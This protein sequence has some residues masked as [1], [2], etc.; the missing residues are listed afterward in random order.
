MSLRASPCLGLIQNGMTTLPIPTYDALM[1]PVLKHVAK[2]PW[3]MGELVR[4]IADD[5][6]LPAEDRTALLP[7][8]STTILGSRVHWAKTYLKQA[9]LVEQPKRGTVQ[10]TP[11]GTAVLAAKPLRID[12]EFLSKY[13]SFARFA[14]KA[15]GQGHKDQLPLPTGAQALP[16]PAADETSSTPIEAINTAANLIED[17]LRDSLLARLYESGPRFFERVILDVLHGMRY[18]VSKGGARQQLGGTGDGGVDGVINEDPLGLDRIYLQAKLYK[19][20]SNVGGP[21]VQAFIGALMNRG[22]QKGVLITT[23]DF[24]GGARQAASNAG[25]LRIV[26]MNGQELTDAMVRYDVGV[27]TTKVVSIKDVDSD[28][29]DPSGID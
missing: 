21:A 4:R 1:L 27:R 8:G 24:T 6:S 11:S 19:A 2:Q 20:G 9:G 16:A 25:G 12:A 22:A 13:P 17:A 5:L 7:G 28:Y 3:Q 14:G 15:G 23:S 29:F 10:I 26:L 18:G